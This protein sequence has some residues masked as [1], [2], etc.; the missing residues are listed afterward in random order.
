MKIIAS[1]FNPIDYQMRENKR[2][3]SPVLG[4]EF[5]GVVTSIGKSVKDFKPGDAVFCGSGSMGS[6]G[7][8]AEYISV[9]ESIVALKPDSISFQQAA[10]LPFV[11]LT[12]LQCLHRMKLQP[13]AQCSLPAVQ[14]V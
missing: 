12:A 2:L 4:R 9:P 1:G 6:N 13:I 11:G 7:T 8:Y 5:S 10:A 14:M 3:H